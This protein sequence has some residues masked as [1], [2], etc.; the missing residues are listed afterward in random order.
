[1]P[2]GPMLN[3]MV[4]FDHDPLTTASTVIVP[5]GARCRIRS[6]VTPSEQLTVPKGEPDAVDNVS[7]VGSLPLATSVS[8]PGSVSPAPA[9]APIAWPMDCNS[10]LIFAGSSTWPSPSA[11][12]RTSQAPGSLK[13]AY[14]PDD[15]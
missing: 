12:L 11:S 9:G 7:V 3:R 6:M 5:C 14:R 13:K 4:T 1:M 10:A 15:A 8:P 2:L